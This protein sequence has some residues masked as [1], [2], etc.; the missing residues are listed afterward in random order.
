MLGSGDPETQWRPVHK[1]MKEMHARSLWTT[2]AVDHQETA[3]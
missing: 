2:L 3:T 1:F